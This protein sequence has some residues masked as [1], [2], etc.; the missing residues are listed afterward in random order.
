MAIAK[1]ERSKVVL[2]KSIDQHASMCVDNTE[3]LSEA[4]NLCKELDDDIES[5]VKYFTNCL[6]KSSKNY[7]EWLME[8][9]KL[10]L[11]L[12]LGKKYREKIMNEPD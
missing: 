5:R 7:R 9:Y 3:T 2:D 12:L 11:A 4:K 6:S 10:K 8:D 1:N